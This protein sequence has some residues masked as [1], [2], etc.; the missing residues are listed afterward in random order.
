[1]MR[2]TRKV[3][4]LSILLVAVL[5]AVAVIAEAQQPKKMFRIG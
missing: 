4:G 1:M 3:G 2:A 5:L